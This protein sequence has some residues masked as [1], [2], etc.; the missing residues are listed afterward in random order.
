M[1][2]AARRTS[3]PQRSA[4][5]R[6]S[7]PPRRT[8]DLSHR[9]PEGGSVVGVRG[10][11]AHESGFRGGRGSRPARSVRSDHAA[12]LRLLGRRR[13]RRRDRR[14][15]AGR[16]GTRE[17]L[18]VS[19][20]DPDAAPLQAC[21]ERRHHWSGVRD[22]H[23][24]RMQE[25]PPRALARRSSSDMWLA[26]LGANSPPHRTSNDTPAQPSASCSSPPRP[27]ALPRDRILER[28]V[29]RRAISR[30]LLPPPRVPGRSSRPCRQARRQR[31]GGRG[32]E[33]QSAS[34]R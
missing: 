19:E 7:P 24:R 12:M 20:Q 13:R 28:A 1:R 25:L 16:G 6:R 5:A 3:K 31:P 23:S 21:N 27:P 2:Q 34:T 8:R 26:P 11:H 4:L 33:D 9:R 10:D 18:G 14:P 29:R 32:S 17:A 22:R 15:R 30:V